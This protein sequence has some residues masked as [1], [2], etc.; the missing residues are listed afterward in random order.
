MIL[1]SDNQFIDLI[2]KWNE[3]LCNHNML[4]TNRSVSYKFDSMNALNIEKK[5]KK[6][7]NNESK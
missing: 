2:E 3:V 5:K 1:K 6:E 7:K 4:D